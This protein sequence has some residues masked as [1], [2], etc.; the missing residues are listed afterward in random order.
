MMSFE[1]MNER[2]CIK[3]LNWHYFEYFG[4]ANGCLSW[5]TWNI[6]LAQSLIGNDESRIAHLIIFSKLWT[7][8]LSDIAKKQDTT[9]NLADF[10]GFFNCSNRLGCGIKWH[11]FQIRKRSSV[12]IVDYSW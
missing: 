3:R 4:T 8:I 6:D 12:W 10:D 11:F 9:V 5:Y 7:S 1:W 2:S